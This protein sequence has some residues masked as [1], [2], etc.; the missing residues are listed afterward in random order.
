MDKKIEAINKDLKD[1]LT[2]IR[3]KLLK[4]GENFPG[5]IDKSG[6]GTAF[7]RPDDEDKYDAI[8]QLISFLDCNNYD[9]NKTYIIPGLTI[10]GVKDN[11]GKER[12]MTLCLKEEDIE[13]LLRNED[14]YK[15]L[16]V[17]FPAQIYQFKYKD[18]NVPGKTFKAPRPRLITEGQDEYEAFLKNYYEQNGEQVKL[19]NNGTNIREAYTHEK[20]NYRKNNTIDQSFSSEYYRTYYQNELKK[21]QPQPQAHNNP[22]QT[23]QEYTFVDSEPGEK[24]PFP[25]KISGFFSSVKQFGSNGHLSSGI[26]TILGAALAVGAVGFIVTNAYTMPIAITAVVGV[27]G[28]MLLIKPFK[29]IKEKIK[30]FFYGKKIPQQPQT[31]NNPTQQQGGGTQTTPPTGTGGNGNPTGGG[32]PGGTNPSPQPSPTPSGATPPPTKDDNLT[33]QIE[34]LLEEMGQSKNTYEDLNN[35]I[36]VLQTELQNIDPS[37][38]EYQTKETT[39]KD[40]KDKQKQLLLN[41]YNMIANHR[42][43]NTQGGKSL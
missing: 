18:K 21:T 19:I 14:K 38:P 32:N 24:I 27:G 33:I 25:Q 17:N 29:K 35:R 5:H 1:E 10:K 30:D 43:D 2:K 7:I 12:Q 8:N 15:K 34:S 36:K 31:P 13:T 40:L 9:K 4:D 6:N 26:R 41:V 11:K 39:L 28:G 23:G 22:A 42:I 20:I 3:E 37:S 16:G